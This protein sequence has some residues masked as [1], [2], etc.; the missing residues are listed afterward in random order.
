MEPTFISTSVI[1]AQSAESIVRCSLYI[2]GARWDKQSNVLIE[3]K[4]KEL[5]PPMPVIFVKGDY[6]IVVLKCV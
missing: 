2:D 3:G 5:C 1:R 4:L 6:R